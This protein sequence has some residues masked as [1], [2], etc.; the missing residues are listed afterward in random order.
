MSTTVNAVDRPLLTAKAPEF[1]RTERRR[2]PAGCGLIE[3]APLWPK[4]GENIGTLARTADAIGGCLV[5]PHESDAIKAAR[6]GNTIG[7]HNAPI[8]WI[9]DPVGWLADQSTQV[10][11]V[12]LTHGAVPLRAVLPVVQPTVIVLGHEVNGI[13]KEAWP[14][15]DWAI[16]IPMHGVGNS[17]NVAVAGSLA[18]YKLAGLA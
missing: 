9:K 17:L 10:V 11:A 13:P 1:I 5:V 6:R 2:T 7:A 8:H 14:F 15:I 12:E 16:E 4:R 18:A 3:I